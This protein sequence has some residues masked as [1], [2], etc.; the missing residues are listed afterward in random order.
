MMKPMLNPELANAIDADRDRD[1]TSA[2]VSCSDDAGRSSLEP[3]RRVA[4][5]LAGMIEAA[6]PELACEVPSDLAARTMARIRAA[7]AAGEESP[8]LAGS[9]ERLPAVGSVETAG[10][11]RAS[12]SK[13]VR[14]PSAPTLSARHAAALD[15]WLEAGEA[16]GPPPEF[17]RLA[18]ALDT[19][20]GPAAL[21]SVPDSL[22][23]RTLARLDTERRAADLAS[24]IDRFRG[25][26]EPMRSP[27]AG[28]IGF[29][30]RMRGGVRQVL[31]AAALLF[32]GSALLLPALSKSAMEA[33]RL[34]CMGNLRAA[35]SAFAQYAADYGGVLPKAAGFSSLV[36]PGLLGEG[37]LV[38]R[39]SQSSPYRALVEP[40]GEPGSANSRHLGLLVQ[41]GG[42]YVK[43]ERLVC[44]GKPVDPAEVAE[45]NRNLWQIPGGAGYSYQSQEGSEPLKMELA[46][47]GLGL[48][49][50]RSPLFAVRNDRLE[51]R[52]DVSIMRP[53]QIH[54]GE[55]QNLLTAGGAVVWTVQPH[56]EASSGVA[57]PAVDRLW[58]SDAPSASQSSDGLFVP[59]DIQVDTVLIP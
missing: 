31:T 41:A 9:T 52:E 7:G 49:G 19:G 20:L 28:R 40:G 48:L 50:D 21:G 30:G 5:R 27:V 29:G 47:S 42:G 38:A 25:P 37:G 54:L 2:A 36:P 18:R 53:S 24:Q 43:A 17:A 16:A 11:A 32:I 44:H 10:A 26:A 3:S 56:V 58:V 51:K 33:G 59:T 15:A 45:T 35:G 39:V 55:G 14:K 12:T 46:R 13:E 22:V 4:S 34:A 23:T 1:R 8:G 6:D 57:G